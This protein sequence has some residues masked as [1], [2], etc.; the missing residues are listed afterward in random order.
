MYINTE[1]DKVIKEDKLI[2]RPRTPGFWVS[3]EF[4]L[5]PI[6]ALRMT[7]GG[8]MGG[9]QWFEYIERIPL[10]DLLKKDN[11]VVTTWDGKERF[12][13]MKYVVKAENLT[14]ASAVYH[15]DNTNF[16]I[17]DYKYCYLTE[18]KVKLTTDKR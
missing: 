8:G 5:Q 16:K 10:E 2:G 15:S 13:N 11:M 14:I 6:T 3:E 7:C 18:D 1:F 4:E 17:G 12:I 9:A